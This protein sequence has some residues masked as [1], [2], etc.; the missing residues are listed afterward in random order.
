MQSIY[1]YILCWSSICPLV[2]AV[3]GMGVWAVQGTMRARWYPFD[4]PRRRFHSFNPKV[5]Q[6]F[7]NISCQYISWYF[8]YIK[9]YTQIYVVYHSLHGYVLRCA[10][11]LCAG[12]HTCG[13]SLSLLHWRGCSEQYTAQACSSDSTSSQ[14]ESNLIRSTRCCKI[15]CT[16][17]YEYIQVCT[18]MY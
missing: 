1:E 7:C 11:F 3:C 8:L 10:V 15:V 18:S 13:P 5:C 2:F 9:V 12:Y 17:M 16:S 4:M 14:G 6:A